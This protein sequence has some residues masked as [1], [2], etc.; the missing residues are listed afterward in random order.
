MSET[1]DVV[2]GFAPLKP[3][4]IH[5]LCG[6]CGRKQ[7]NMPRYD[8]DPANAVVAMLICEKHM[9]GKEDP[10]TYFDVEGNEIAERNWE[11]ESDD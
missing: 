10:C 9:G 3:N 7:S 8:A 11:F 4:R 5:L 6:K 1:M 2:G